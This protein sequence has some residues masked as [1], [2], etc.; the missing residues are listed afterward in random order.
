MI[1]AARFSVEYP[2]AVDDVMRFVTPERQEVIARHNLGLGPS[3]TDLR[4]YLRASVK[5][6][7]RAVELFNAHVPDH[8]DGLDVLDVGGFLGAFP[9]TLRRLGA[10]VTLAEVYGYYG[11]ALDGLRAYLV[12]EGVEVWDVDF[13]EEILPGER[14]FTLVTNMAMLE[15]LAS[16]PRVLMG[17]LRAVTG[18][19]GALVIETPNICYWPTRWGLLRGRSVHPPLDVVYGSEVPFLGH[20]R[21]YTIR[22]LTELLDWSGFH[23]EEVT[24]LNYTSLW[25]GGVARRLVTAAVFLWPTLAF[26]SCR[27]ILLA[28]AKPVPHAADG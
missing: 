22:E 16:S 27:E 13:T 17:N 11:E 26:P 25:H 12:S 4:H 3:R 10:T 15:H 28:L 20:H 18:K 7:L 19:R 21:E 1:D 23:L 2:R 5:R 6:Y 14:R 9:L 8:R 24:T